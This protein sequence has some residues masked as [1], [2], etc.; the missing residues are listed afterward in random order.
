MCIGNSHKHK[1]SKDSEATLGIYDI[2]EKRRGDGVL[3]FRSENGNLQIVEE[4]WN[5]CGSQIPTRQLGNNRTQV[6]S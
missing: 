1:N 2:F 3:D 5:T 4:E 6:S